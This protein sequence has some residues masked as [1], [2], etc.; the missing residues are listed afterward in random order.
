MKAVEIKKAG[1]AELLEVEQPRAGRGEV[2][3]RVH[4]AGICASDIAAYMGRHP[5]RIPPVITGHEAAGVV[6]ALGEGISELSEGD[7]VIVEPHIG[8]GHC[9]FCDRGDYNLCKEKRVLGTTDWPGSFAEYVVVPEICAYRVPPDIP[10][11]V[12]SLIEPLCVGI[13]AAER[14]SLEPGASVAILGSG[15]IG[16]TLLLAVLQKEPDIVICSD[17][18]TS[19]LEVARALGATHAIDAGEQNL[20]EEVNSITGGRGVDVCVVAVSS[21]QVVAQALAVT[22]LKGSVVLI[23]LFEEPSRIDLREIQ[24]RERQL[25]GTLMYTRRDYLEAVRLLPS[26]KEALGKLITHHIRIEELPDMLESISRGKAANSIKV[27]VD[28][29]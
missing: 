13:H 24:L 29:S 19:S 20:E 2:L 23:A 5:Y 9:D 26:L 17:V 12:V 3:V 25:I 22:K 6:V 18:R 15:T 11:P 8:C 7:P 10:L 14:A 4:A 16:L 27:V 28:L 1:F 21:D